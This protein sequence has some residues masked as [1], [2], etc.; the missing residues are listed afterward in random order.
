L[1][2]SQNTKNEDREHVQ[3]MA[4]SLRGWRSTCCRRGRTL[5]W[6]IYEFVKALLL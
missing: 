2:E 1:Q 5:K 6:R 4:E 3:Q